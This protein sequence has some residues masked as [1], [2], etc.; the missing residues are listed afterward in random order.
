M[1]IGIDARIILNPDLGEA[2]GIGYYTF[3]LIRHLLKMDAD[4]KADLFSAMKEKTAKKIN[5]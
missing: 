1:R 2:I 4:K 3:M 5:F